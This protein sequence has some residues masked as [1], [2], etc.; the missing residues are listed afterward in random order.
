MKIISLFVLAFFANYCYGQQNYIS[1]IQAYQKNYVATHEVV[2]A[3]DKKYFRFFSIDS[4]YRVNA[5]FEKI[6][7]TIG[8]SMKTSGKGSQQYFKYGKL[9]FSI[10]GTKLH[11]FVYQSKDLLKS[12]DYADYLFLPFSDL[13]TGD[14]TY[15]SGRYIDLAIPQIIHN[16]IVIDFN[17]AYNPYCAYSAE[18]HC[19]I[20]PKE[21]LLP[22][23]IN[24]GEMNFG[25]A[26]H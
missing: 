6:T 18:Y 19:P 25:K 16:K 15:G 9:S 8:F 2:K 20:P 11:L 23:A 22:V 26:S 5:V 10:K 3:K 21:N 13:T 4:N 17:E 12:K 7:D 1:E 14:K 24:A